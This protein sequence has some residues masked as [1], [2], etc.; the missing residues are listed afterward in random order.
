MT[1]M[2]T[3]ARQ[4]GSRLVDERAGQVETLMFVRAGIEHGLGAGA[5]APHLGGVVHAKSAALIQAAGMGEDV[6]TAGFV[7]VEADHLPADRALGGDRVKPLSAQQLYELDDPYRDVPHVVS[8]RSPNQETPASEQNYDGASGP[9]ERSA[10]LRPVL[11][12]ARS[13]NPIN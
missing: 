2:P 12:Y 1:I 11:R 4:R 6:A 3:D 5:V 8:S 9:P 7:D 13:I 10:G